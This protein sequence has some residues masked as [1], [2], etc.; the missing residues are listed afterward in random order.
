MK[1]SKCNYE[2]SGHEFDTDKGIMCGAC[3]SDNADELVKDKDEHGTI[4]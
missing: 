2:I 1:C 4:K 3:A